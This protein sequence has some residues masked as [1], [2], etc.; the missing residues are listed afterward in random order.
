M[1]SSTESIARRLRM[2]KAGGEVGGIVE[3]WR[4]IWCAVPEVRASEFFP[5]LRLLLIN[6]CCINRELISSCS[7]DKNL[8]LIKFNDCAISW[9][10]HSPLFGM[11]QAPLSLGMFIK[12]INNRAEC[13]AAQTAKGGSECRKQSQTLRESVTKHRNCRIY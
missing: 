4:R 7:K 2:V 10:S 3:R 1:C 6:K 9:Q 11:T 12:Q 5:C 8:L 13:S